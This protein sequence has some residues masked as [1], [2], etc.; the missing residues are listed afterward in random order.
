[1]PRKIVSQSPITLP[2]VGELLSLRRDSFTPLQLRVYNYASTFSKL[3]AEKARRLTRE[4]RERFGLEPEEACQ[5][6]NICPRDVNEAR[7]ILS[8]YRR[9]VSSI[10][11][12]DQK[13]SEIVQTIESY[14]REEG[15][16]ERQVQE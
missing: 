12:S 3:T 15:I 5:L 9:L 10:L 13:L 7:A 14:L 4:L 11:F 6:V 8:G 1:M 16:E 2:E